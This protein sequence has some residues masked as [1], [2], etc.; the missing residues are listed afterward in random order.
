MSQRS[1]MMGTS[2]NTIK[3][4]MQTHTNDVGPGHYNSSGSIGV[5]QT[6]SKTRNYPA[7]TLGLPRS[8]FSLNPETKRIVTNK[9]GTPS[10]NIYNFPHDNPYF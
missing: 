5:R 9:D 7:A 10:P 1:F 6:L 4:A 8:S 2:V 3:R